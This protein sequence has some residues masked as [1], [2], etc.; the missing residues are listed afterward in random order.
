MKKYVFLLPF[1]LLLA[2]SPAKKYADTKTYWEE[3]IKKLEA[4][5]KIENYPD[6]AILYI[7]SSSIRLWKNIDEDMQP[8][9]SI[10]RGYGGAH[11]Y[12]LIHF[13]DRLVSPHKIQALVIFVANDITGGDADIPP[14]EVLR[15]FK[16][17]VS[18]V[19]KSHPNI[20]IFQIAITPT[21]SRWAVWDQTKQAN[22]LLQAYCN[23]TQGLHFIETEEAFLDGDGQP[24]P[25]LFIQDMLHLKQVGY[26]IWKELIKNELDAVLK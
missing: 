21:P 12:D 1:L 9:N 10:Q 8:Y 17:T 13:T 16:Y 22:E 20:P 15:L 23:R 25:E 19:R 7:G 2:C 26:D 4:Q 14:K 11:F 5:D 6:D 3:D 24:R 18:E